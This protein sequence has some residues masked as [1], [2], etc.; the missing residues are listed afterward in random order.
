VERLAR[1]G[2]HGDTRRKDFV[3]RRPFNRA[4]PEPVEGLR[5]SLEE[6][7]EM[8]VEKHF[9]KACPGPDPGISA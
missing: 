6:A 5:T 3:P 1:E 7:E 4:C 2:G 8:K 9:L